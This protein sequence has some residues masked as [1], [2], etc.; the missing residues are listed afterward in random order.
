M[1]ALLLTYRHNQSLQTRA[2][3]TLC[4]HE[5][6]KSLLQELDLIHFLVRSFVDD[7]C[8]DQK[9]TPARDEETMIIAKD[10]KLK[11]CDVWD[12]YH[13]LCFPLRKELGLSDTQMLLPSLLPDCQDESASIKEEVASMVKEEPEGSTEQQPDAATSESVVKEEEG[14][15]ADEKEAE[16]IVSA[17]FDC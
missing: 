9:K 16:P 15:R 1:R 3:K 14:P 12:L 6:T 17:Q 13:D 5:G 4:V 8:N 2:R 11:K 7:A 10:K